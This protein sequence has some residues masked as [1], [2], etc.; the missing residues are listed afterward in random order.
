MP[1]P[2]SLPPAL[3]DDALDTHGF[4]QIHGP[5]D[6]LRGEVEHFIHGVFH[7]RYGANVTQF[8]PV[9][10]SLR[11]PTGKLVAAA[12]YRCA[13]S[14]PLFLERYLDTPVE[15]LLAGPAASTSRTQIVEV[16][17]LAAGRSGAGRRLIFLLGPHLAAQGYRWVVS[18]L[19][20]EL[21]HVFVR[22]GIVPL[23][24]G[25]ADPVLL[26]ADAG[27]WG[28]YYD[29]RPVVLAGQLDLALKALTRQGF[30]LRGARESTA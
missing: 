23:S 9:L 14:T 17:H 4:L 12:G 19:T 16:G 3:T 2:N 26:G 30:G 10:V 6:P 24:L 28:N 22:L 1:S 13:G 11:D 20:E 8:A 21:R 5:Q 27:S 29:H 18:T 7:Q 15:R 25:V